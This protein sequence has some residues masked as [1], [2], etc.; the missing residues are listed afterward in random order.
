MAVKFGAETGTVMEEDL[1]ELLE[2]LMH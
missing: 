1:H 2:D